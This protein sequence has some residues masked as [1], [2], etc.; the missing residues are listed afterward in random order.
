[1]C[2]DGNKDPK[3][4]KGYKEERKNI[5]IYIYLV[6]SYDCIRQFQKKFFF[7]RRKEEEKEKKEEERKEGM[8]MLLLNSDTI[9]ENEN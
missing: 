9:E 2:R 5:A 1:M 3:G 8:R 6:F 7:N 4:S